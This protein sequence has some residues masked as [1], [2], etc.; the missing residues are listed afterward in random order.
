[1][2]SWV[3]STQ[4]F[5]RLGV[6]MAQTSASRPFLLCGLEKANG[7]KKN[8]SAGCFPANSATPTQLEFQCKRHSSSSGWL[9]K[10]YVFI[11]FFFFYVLFPEY[12]RHI[13]RDLKKYERPISGRPKPWNL[14]V[15]PITACAVWWCLMVNHYLVDTH[16]DT[17]WYYGKP[18][19]TSGFYCPADMSP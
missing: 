15:D 2:W 19:K 4:K 14:D 9:Q 3:L 18:W 1:M 17:R 6:K 7:C 12:V 8:T 11:V 13:L 10:L 16:V 5:A